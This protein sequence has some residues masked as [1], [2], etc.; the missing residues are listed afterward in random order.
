MML[1]IRW[2]GREMGASLFH[3][4]IGHRILGSAQVPLAE[5][6]DMVHALAPD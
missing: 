5:H 2:T 4:N 3:C 1:P 6:D